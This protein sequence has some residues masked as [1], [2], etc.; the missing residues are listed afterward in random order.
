MKTETESELVSITEIADRLGVQKNTVD[1]W[2]WRKLFPAAD[3]DLGVGPI[4][5]WETVR[6]WAESTG[7]LPSDS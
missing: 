5:R 2:R 7:R 6:S 3:F 4:W 1:Q